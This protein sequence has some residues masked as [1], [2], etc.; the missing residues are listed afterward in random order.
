M[1]VTFTR[2]KGEEVV[3]GDPANPLGI[4]VISEVSR[5]SVDIGFASFP[6]RVNIEGRVSTERNG[7]DSKETG[8]GS[9]S[10]ARRYHEYSGGWSV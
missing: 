7:Y 5:G 4:V 1:T 6:E 3:I 10:K 9:D 8:P 2:K